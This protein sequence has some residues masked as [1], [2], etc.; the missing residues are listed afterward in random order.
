M[1]PEGTAAGV[2][3]WRLE[4]RLGVSCGVWMGVGFFVDTPARGLFCR[5]E[6]VREN[7]EIA[8]PA[9]HRSPPIPID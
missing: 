1:I 8:A 2:Y 3:L 5:R 6:E 4:S 7:S 9:K